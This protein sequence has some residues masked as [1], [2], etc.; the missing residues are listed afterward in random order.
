MIFENRES[1]SPQSHRVHGEK[2]KKSYF[3]RKDAKNA[4]D[5]PEIIIVV[6]KLLTGFDAPR[7]TVLY[8]TK[9]LKDHSLL[10]AIARV[11]RLYEGKDFGYIIDYYGILGNLDKALND[12]SSLSDFD[13]EDIE[14]VLT[15]VKEEVSKLAE[16]HSQLWD[17]FR[18]IENKKDEEAFEQLLFDEEIRDKFYKLTGLFAKSL[19]LAFS[20]VDFIKQTPKELIERY[21]NDARNFLKL[22]ASVQKRYSD[23]IEY[24]NYEKQI[25]KLVDTYIPASEI[26]KITELVNIFET[27]KFQKEVERV[28]GDAAKADMIATRTVKTINERMEEDPAF[29]LKFSKMLEAVIEEFRQKRISDAD[30]LASVKEI[31]NSVI[32]R[33]G[34]DVPGELVDKDVAKAFYGVINNIIE[35]YFTDKLRL[36][37]I[38]TEMALEIDKA[39][40]ENKVVDW[41]QKNDIQNIIRQN[42]D[43]LIFDLSTKHSLKLDISDVDEIIEQCLNIAKIRY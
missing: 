22:R 37:T 28:V 11:N 2:K 23:T 33:T 43:D 17:I 19:R 38:S 1:Y 39:V 36:K 29:Y 32:N 8:I 14:G 18:E 30:Y 13:E 16:R 26:L 35:K 27:E 7:N 6:D 25:Q 42:I 4:K 21:K 20:T 40:N 10:Q 3:N 12:Y 15:N 41:Q 5:E 34:D 9:S 24:K 31:M